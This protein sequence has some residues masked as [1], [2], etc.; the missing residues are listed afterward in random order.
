MHGS[1]RRRMLRVPEEQLLKAL[2]RRKRLYAREPLAAL[3]GPTARAVLRAAI[4]DL[5]EPSE[6]RELG[7]GVFV[8]RPFGW[9]KAPGEPDLT[10]L[11][12]HEAYSHSIANRR[13][14]ELQR[15]A[16]ESSLEPVLWARLHSHPQVEG[17]PAAQV[18]EPDRPTVS[19]ADARRVADDFV[20]QQTLRRG[21]EDVADAFH[22]KALRGFVE[23]KD[24]RLIVRLRGIQEESVL[25][26]F[27]RNLTRRLETVTDLSQGFHVRRGRELPIAGLRLLGLWDEHGNRSHAGAER[28]ASQ[29]PQPG[30][31]GC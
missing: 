11:L 23:P 18:A 12:A 5:A 27:D 9:G 16:E 17:I 21:L 2:H 4:L 10:P 15:L 7:T 20:I 30:R 8:E 29:S 14:Q 6:W 26:F 28:L 31:N 13:L 19:L 1:C 3:L 22:W 25:A 24:I